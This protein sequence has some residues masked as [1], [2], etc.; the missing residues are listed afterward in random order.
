LAKEGPG[1]VQ[2][3]VM[4]IRDLKW[5]GIPAW[6]PEWGF[7]E[8]GVGEEGV[9]KD[10]QLRNDQLACIY[11]LASH[12]DHSRNGVIL[13]EDP[14]HLKI[15]CQKLKESIGKRLSE[16][17]DLKID[18]SLSIPKKGPK[19]VRPQIAQSHRSETILKRNRP[20]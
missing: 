2:E 12:L 7:A 9:L 14:A 15:L 10:V 16:V 1:V 17:G 11:V 4:R 8:E 3:A 6:P 18:F 20:H 13:L 5:K 19:Q